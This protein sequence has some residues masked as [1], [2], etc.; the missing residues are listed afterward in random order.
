MYLLLIIA[1]RGQYKNDNSYRHINATADSEVCEITCKAFLLN[2]GLTSVILMAY[3]GS[4]L[5]GRDLPC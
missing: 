2:I 5:A 3:Q 1:L 4:A